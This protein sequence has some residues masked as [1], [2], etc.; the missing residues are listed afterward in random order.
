MGRAMFRGLV[1]GMLL[2]FLSGKLSRAHF[3]KRRGGWNECKGPG[4]PPP[5]PPLHGRVPV[6]EMGEG[7]KKM[8]LLTDERM[9]AIP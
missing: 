7:S 1:F 9:K 2:P 6:R 3:L 8:I 5:P 4:K